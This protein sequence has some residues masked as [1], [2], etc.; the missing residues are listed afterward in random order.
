MLQLDPQ[1]PAASQL[2]RRKGESENHPDSLH[3]L[4]STP[5]VVDGYIYGVCAR[6]ELR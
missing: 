6:G 2:W 3:G 4:M 5:C 1:R